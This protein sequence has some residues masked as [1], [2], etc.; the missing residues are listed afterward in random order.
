MNILT[1]AKFLRLTQQAQKH[2]SQAR[3]VE[4]D[5]AISG[6]FCVSDMLDILGKEIDAEKKL[7]K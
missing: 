1:S 4:D 6:L 3:H 7:K 2:Y 5:H